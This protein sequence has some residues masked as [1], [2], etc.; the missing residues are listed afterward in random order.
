ML[1]EILDVKTLKSHTEFNKRPIFFM[2]ANG[3]AWIG[4]HIIP[5]ASD[6]LIL[7]CLSLF[8]LQEGT[9][10]FTNGTWKH[11]TLFLGKCVGAALYA[12]FR[13]QIREF[14]GIT[15]YTYGPNVW[16]C[17]CDVLVWILRLSIVA[18]TIQN[19]HPMS[20]QYLQK[21]ESNHFDW[22]PACAGG[23]GKPKSGCSCKLKA[24]CRCYFAN[25]H[26]T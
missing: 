21:H 23:R 1:H 20:P 12:Q 14:L 24:F 13:A 5:T 16:A 3:S 19:L 6:I 10:R 2:P 8:A 11:S 25:R 18:M 15:F 22:N 17:F 7:L 26:C 9:A 4:T